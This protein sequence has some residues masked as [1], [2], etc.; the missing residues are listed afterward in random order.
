MVKYIWNTHYPHFL[1]YI[2]ACVVSGSL[3]ARLRECNTDIS[4]DNIYLRAPSTEWSDSHVLCV[5]SF[6]SLPYRT[7]LSMFGNILQHISCLT[8]LVFCIY[9]T[10]KKKTTRS[11]CLA[12][13]FWYQVSMIIVGILLSRETM[14]CAVFKAYLR[15]R[16]KPGQELWRSWV[17]QSSESPLGFTNAGAPGRTVLPTDGVLL[18]KYDIIIS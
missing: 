14:V 9:Q 5:I 10:C 4:I 7:L 3:L 2:T 8:W 1:T 15:R 16:Y 18:G 6:L 13:A 12:K 17:A 11:I